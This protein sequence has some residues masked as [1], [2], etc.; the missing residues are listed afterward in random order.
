MAV[1]A[2]QQLDNVYKNSKIQVNLL[3][4]QI[5]KLRAQMGHE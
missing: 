1:S 2:K 4:N 5:K 3:R